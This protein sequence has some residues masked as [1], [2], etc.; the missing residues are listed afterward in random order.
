MTSDEARRA[1][2]EAEVRKAHDRVKTDLDRTLPTDA[3]RRLRLVA[4][5]AA[6]PALER[7][8]RTE[9]ES[10][11]TAVLDTYRTVLA[12]C[13]DFRLA[14]LRYLVECREAGEEPGPVEEFVERLMPAILSFQAAVERDL[15]EFKGLL[16]AIQNA[17]AA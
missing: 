5:L 16:V 10:A 15:A 4:D 2:L 14:A 3:M 12:D 13:H 6:I 8:R 9:M 11:G 17:E 1:S 7:W